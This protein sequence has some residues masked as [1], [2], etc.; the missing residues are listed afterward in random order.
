[1]DR[2]ARAIRIL[3]DTSCLALLVYC[4]FA[5][6]DHVYGIVVFW[7]VSLVVFPYARM[8]KR[9]PGRRELDWGFIVLGVLIVGAGLIRDVGPVHSLLHGTPTND[10]MLMGVA[11]ALG[12]LTNVLYVSRPP[13]MG[14]LLLGGATLVAGA[15]WLWFTIAAAPPA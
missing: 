6:I 15:V 2:A 13:S 1:M 8:A 14:R 5:G 12:G 11:L 4:L 3:V 7:L 10:S 9:P